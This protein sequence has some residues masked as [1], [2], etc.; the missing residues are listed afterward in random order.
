MIVRTSGCA[1]VDEMMA[2]AI[3]LADATGLPVR[4]RYEAALLDLFVGEDVGAFDKLGQSVTT[5]FFPDLARGIT[6]W[7]R[8]HGDGRRHRRSTWKAAAGAL[9]V[10]AEM[11]PAVVRRLAYGPIPAE[12]RAL[13]DRASC[14]PAI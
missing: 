8:G 2:H 10:L 7:G 1:W 4:I 11:R 14:P 6:S 3:T 5:A 9:A 13:L 12:L